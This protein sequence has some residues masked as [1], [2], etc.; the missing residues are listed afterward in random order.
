MTSRV[1]QDSALCSGNSVGIQFKKQT[2]NPGDTLSEHKWTTEGREGQ[3]SQTPRT[4][5]PPL[6]LT[7]V[8]RT[9]SVRTRACVRVITQ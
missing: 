9:E 4:A 8:E 2:N 5:V 3:G 7:L 6:D 1:T